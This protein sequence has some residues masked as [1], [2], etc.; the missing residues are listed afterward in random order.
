MNRDLLGGCR[1]CSEQTVT[2]PNGLAEADQPHSV[3][4]GQC[5]LRSRVKSSTGFYAV[6]SQR[7]E[8]TWMVGTHNLVC[9]G[10]GGIRDFHGD[11]I[12]AL[13]FQCERKH[14]RENV[15]IGR[16]DHGEK[17]S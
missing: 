17:R 3:V 7:R 8:P 4:E 1:V 11:L 5:P 13:R 9:S 2:G 12:G 14:K 10:P 16:T 15:G 6:W